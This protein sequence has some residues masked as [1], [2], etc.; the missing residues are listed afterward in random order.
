[1]L[2]Q[3]LTLQQQLRA[4]RAMRQIGASGTSVELRPNPRDAISRTGVW[5]RNAL[6]FVAIA[7]VAA[8][9]S[10]Q[11]DAKSAPMA[12]KDS[13]AMIV[14]AS[15]AANAVQAAPEGVWVPTL[16]PVTV[17][18]EGKD[19]AAMHPFDRVRL[20]QVVA[21]QEKLA[22]VGKDWRD[23]Y[24]VIN[25]ETAWAAREGKS[26]SGEPNYGLA[27]LEM[28]TA[29]SLSIKDPNDPVQ[30]LTATARLVKESVGWAKARGVQLTDAA[31]SVNYNLSTAARNAW[32]GKTL[33]A[34]PYETQRH[35]ANFLQGRQAAEY[36][37]R[38]SALFERALS[39]ELSSRQVTLKVLAEA[40]A[41][42][43]PIAHMALR[44]A[45]NE[46]QLRPVED[47]VRARVRMA[48]VP[49]ASAGAPRASES[50]ALISMSS[51][52][53]KQFTSQI[54]A[55]LEK[56]YGR[57]IA[58][59]PK[60]PVDLGAVRTKARFSASFPTVASFLGDHVNGF[61]AYAAS[62]RTTY[63]EIV[64]RTIGG[65]ADI[66]RVAVRRAQ[67]LASLSANAQ[68]PQQAVEANANMLVRMERW[69]GNAISDHA[70]GSYEVATARDRP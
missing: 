50:M 9:F 61:A 69:V 3:A 64:S 41:A 30:A 14:L 39:R 12:Q 53:L 19:M 31:I 26:K 44:T 11:A 10:P 52:G 28:K 34:L 27:Q 49:Q 57:T 6:G 8:V 66:E 47:E 63:S 68:A 5:S 67:A 56:A 15:Q 4:A 51:A 32:D 38:Q 54:G 18:I 13:P 23:I 36:I 33:E 35:V 60:A 1:M 17:R 43:I 55:A 40:N 65:A 62:M 22:A 70:A 7:T 45:E 58:A 25:A 24:A 37:G 42:A 21:K 20:C 16:P 59:D 2:D 48:Y 46:A 29:N